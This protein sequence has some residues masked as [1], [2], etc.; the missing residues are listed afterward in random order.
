M[1]KKITKLILLILITTFLINC[2]FIHHV[3]FADTEEVINLM[4]N[5]VGG[6]ISIIYYIK[7]LM[8]VIIAFCANKITTFIG[9]MDGVI[10]A[11]VIFTLSPFHIFFNKLQ[12]T[13]VNFFDLS[14]SST[15]ATY[16]IRTAVSGWFYIMRLISASVLMAILIYVGIRMAISAI[17]EEKAK[18]KKMLVDWFSSIALIFLL[19][20]ICIFTVYA[21]TAIVKALE[22]VATNTD[23]TDTMNKIAILGAVGVGINSISAALVYCM[24]TFQTL[25][26]LIAYINRMLKIA[27]LIIISPLISITYSIDRMGDGKSQALDAWL[28]EFVYTILIQP[29]HCIVYI[30][31]IGSAFALL[32]NDN[33]VGVAISSLG[34]EYNQLANGVLAILCVKFTKDAEEIVR[35]I[36][37]FKD[38]NNLTS[39]AAGMAVTMVAAKKAQNLGKSAR[40]LTTSAKNFKDS[41]L[42]KAIS[43]DS[44]NGRFKN[45]ADKIDNSK[46]MQ[47][48]KN[49]KAGKGIGKGVDIVGNG[50]STVGSKVGTL[51]NKAGTKIGN[52]G[53]K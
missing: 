33:G 34:T 42:F 4:A 25:G 19:Q 53:K 2:V 14:I 26:L 38:D 1:K 18:Y 11:G 13:D 52:V 36:F 8:V 5:L 47:L 21:N 37:G 30:A 17:A 50:I 16:K 41:N 46:G 10:D 45:L 20:Y 28:K 24:L 9:K 31:L 3:T 49:T 15:T 6:V 22:T 51:A 29:F 48:A 23:I 35:K 7:K 32:T 44:K 12:I 43:D 27:F 39:M 40:K